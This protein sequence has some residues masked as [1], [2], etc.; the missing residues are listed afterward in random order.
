MKVIDEVSLPIIGVIP[1]SIRILALQYKVKV[2]VGHFPI[3]IL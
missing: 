2:P 1:R 3:L